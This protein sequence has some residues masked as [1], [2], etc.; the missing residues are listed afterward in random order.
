MQKATI[1]AE[2]SGYK[3]RNKHLDQDNSEAEEAH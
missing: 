2:I 3:Q 1:I